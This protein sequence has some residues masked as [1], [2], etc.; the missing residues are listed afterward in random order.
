M[1]LDIINKKELSQEEETLNLSTENLKKILG[2]QGLLIKRKNQ[3][4]EIKIKTGT[5]DE[6]HKTISRDLTEEEKTKI[7]TLLGV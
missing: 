1:L 5:K 4:L 3:Y 7:R 6:N 2:E